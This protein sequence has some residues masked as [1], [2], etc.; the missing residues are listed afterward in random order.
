MLAPCKPIIYP[1]LP[2]AHI[3]TVGSRPASSSVIGTILFDPDPKKNK[4]KLCFQQV[5]GLAAGQPFLILD[6]PIGNCELDGACRVVL[7]CER[8]PSGGGP[9]MGA[10]VW[11]VYFNGKI[12][13]FGW[14]REVVEDCVTGWALQSLGAVTAGVGVLPPAPPSSSPS[15]Y[16]RDCSSSSSSSGRGRLE[17]LRGK[18]KR[19]VG[20]ANSESYHLVDPAG[21]L[22]G[23]ELSFFFVRL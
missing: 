8:A 7:E 5:D 2:C 11:T 3:F 15:H 20:S 6:L 4:V 19:V 23:H 1:N 21:C 22:S 12:V 9:L 14:R 16:G 17:Y 18:F 13:G 10:A